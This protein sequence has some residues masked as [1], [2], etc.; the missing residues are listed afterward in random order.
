MSNQLSEIKKRWKLPKV[1]LEY[2]S[3]H[4][5]GD[6]IEGKNFVNDLLL[7]GLSDLIEGQYGY[8][9]NPIDKKTIKDWQKEYVVVATDGGDPY[10]L[11]LS[12]SDGNDAPILYAMHGEGKWNF[13]EYAESFTRF[14]KDLGVS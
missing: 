10:V 14:I 2:L 5:E 12:K 4:C 1:Y 8:S 3:T 11:D 9:Y 13:K 6:Y 7:F